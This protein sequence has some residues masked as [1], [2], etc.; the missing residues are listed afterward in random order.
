MRPI[1]PRQHGDAVLLDFRGESE[2]R[3]ADVA[4]HQVYDYLHDAARAVGLDSEGFGPQTRRANITWRQQV[5]GSAIEAGN[6]TGTVPGATAEDAASRGS[7]A[8]RRPTPSLRT[9][10][11][12]RS[13]APLSSCGTGV[14]RALFLARRTSG[15]VRPCGHRRSGAPRNPPSPSRHRVSGSPSPPSC[16]NPSAAGPGW[17][18]R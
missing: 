10:G 7:S 3:A 13:A 9:P 18:F 12:L 5:G 15:A 1:E 14:L 16:P 2:S 17:D 8:G 11:G 4:P 6:I